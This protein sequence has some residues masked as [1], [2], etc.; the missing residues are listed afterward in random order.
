MDTVNSRVSSEDVR[1]LLREVALGR[2]AVGVGGSQPACRGQPAGAMERGS[3][4]QPP[5]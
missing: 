4:P 2:W 1:T 3:F 5:S